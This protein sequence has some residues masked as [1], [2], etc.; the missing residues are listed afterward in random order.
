SQAISFFILLYAFIKGKSNIKLGIK[1]ISKDKNVYLRI[2]KTGLPSLSRQGLASIATALLN[3]N[4]A[5]YGDAAVA[6]MSISGR[7]TFFLFS[8]LLGFGQGFQPVSGYN[9]GA[10]RYDR[11]RKATIF[12]ATVGTIIITTLSAICFIFA[13][14]L[15]TMFRKDDLEVIRIGIIAL[16]AQCLML[17]LTGINVTT[18]MALQSTSHVASATVLAMSR[19]GI[20]F[21]PS[22]L[23]LPKII[24]LLGVQIAQPASDG[25][26]FLL[27][28]YFFVRYLKKLK[29]KM[30]K[31]D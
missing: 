30:E 13:E 17:P 27:T 11:V 8:A 31:Q 21:I 2:L 5:A 3:I 19:Q 20:F 1:K 14:P 10:Q 29:K 15:I 6:A 26:T 7:I 25:L 28:L 16:R 24:G 22:I 9:W 23:I 12:T 18:N 4:A